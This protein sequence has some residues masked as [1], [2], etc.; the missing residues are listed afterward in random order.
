VRSD[1]AF[2]ISDHPIK[3]PLS[4]TASLKIIRSV[5]FF[6]KE[7][8]F[9]WRKPTKLPRLHLFRRMRFTETRMGL[10]YGSIFRP[11]GALP[12]VA[13]RQMIRKINHF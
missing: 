12:G 9:R 2:S 10:Q 8:Q 1:P 6:E 11:F 7:N 3:S 5:S 13:A 4:S